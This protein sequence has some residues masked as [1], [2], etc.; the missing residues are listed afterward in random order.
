[1]NNKN[2]QAL[3]LSALAAALY[4]AFLLPAAAD[5]SM[6]STSGEHG[7]MATVVVTA[8]GF[9]QKIADAPASISVITRAELE[10][11]PFRDLTDA[12]RDLEGVS[13]TGTTNEK[14]ILMRGL[15]GSYTLILVDGKRQSTRDARTNGNAGFEQSFIP[16]LEA[17]ERIEVVRGP[18]S[19]LYGSDAM[20]GVVNIITRKVSREWNGSLGFDTTLQEHSDSGDSYQAQFY[21]D[22]PLK[23]D[24]V[25]LQ[26][27]GK[28]VKRDE[29]ALLAGFT[30]AKDRDLSAR[31]AFTPNANHTVLLKAGV[32]DVRR[33]ASGGNTLAAGA[34]NTYNKHKRNHYNLSHDANWGFGR[35]EISLQRES[36]QR[37]AYTQDKAGT[38][39]ANARAPKI[40][41]TVFDAKLTM[42]LGAHSLVVGAQ[43][44]DAELTDQNPGRRNGV[45]EQFSVTQKAV[46]AEDEW[47]LSDSVS[48]TGGL[49]LDDH[50][51]YGQQWTPRGYVVWHA[52]DL[53]TLKGG[54]SKGF[55]APDIRSVAP[56]YAYSTGGGGCTYGPNGTCG[57]IIGDPDLKAE[58]STNYELSAHFDNK[59]GWTGGATVFY[60]D[61]QDKVSNALVYASPGVPARWVEDPN[62]RLWYSYNIDNATIRGLELTARYKPSRALNVS[63][64][65]TYTDSEQKGGDYAG[66]A[67]TRTPKHAGTV[68]ADWTVKRG[69]TLWS[70][71]T[72]HGKEIN[73]AARSGSNGTLLANGVREYD[74]YTLVDAG[75]SYRVNRSVTVNAALYNIGDKR[76]DD[77]SYNTVGDGRRVWLGLNSSF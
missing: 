10:K 28:Q 56:G 39:V 38:Y 6:T 36:A 62:Y 18:M 25:G 66:Q 26:I 22:G 31:L 40:E 73:A 64:N 33:N 32:T 53:V 55:R 71:A 16:P 50:E 41:N 75:V 49:R 61:F 70:S 65:Y 69:L 51:I 63:A 15:P 12:L 7:K 17:I 68:R 24:T 72:Y 52:T 76:L 3:K 23:S 47:K 74:D 48:L 57:V 67:L 59:A 5:A 8:A 46:F 43:W 34:S 54:V 11:R 1:M 35:S 45:D 60:T 9:E 19:S 37:W 30:G 4:G 21:V 44:N 42:P 58:T 20:G 14:D 27:W 2:T 29:D 13:I 77:L